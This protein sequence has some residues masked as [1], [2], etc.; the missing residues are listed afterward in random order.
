[1]HNIDTMLDLMARAVPN[2]N[3]ICQNNEERI[4]LRFLVEAR[5][6]NLESANSDSARLSIHG[7]WLLHDE[8]DMEVRERLRSYYEGYALSGSIQFAMDA[9]RGPPEQ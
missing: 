3:V 2:N 7:D 8:N 9:V 4:Q 5:L 6:M 1:M